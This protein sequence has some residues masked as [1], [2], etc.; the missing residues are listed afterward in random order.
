MPSETE[1]WL[2]V[3]SGNMISFIRVFMKM[4]MYVGTNSGTQ[5]AAHC[6]SLFSIFSGPAIDFSP[7][8]NSAK[9]PEIIIITHRYFQLDH[10]GPCQ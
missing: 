7:K 6:I 10:R 8:L 2:R 1:S 4:I 5:V 3:K 9:I